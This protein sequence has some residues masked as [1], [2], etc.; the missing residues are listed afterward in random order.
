MMLST[1]AIEIIT[2][3][4]CV[5]RPTKI[6]SGEVKLTVY[7]HVRTWQFHLK[8]HCTVHYHQQ[9]EGCPRSL[10]G[11]GNDRYSRPRAP[12]DKEEEFP[13]RLHKRPFCLPATERKHKYYRLHNLRYVVSIIYDE[14][15]RHILI[16]HMGT[17]Q[18]KW[19][20]D[21]TT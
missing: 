3:Q 18:I 14:S 19:D 4:H 10:S 20:D 9:Q 13:L 8:T 6:D 1:A 16:F 7:V 21:V 12:S 15:K 2:A 11:R 5:S 17:A